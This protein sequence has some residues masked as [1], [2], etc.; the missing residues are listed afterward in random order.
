MGGDMN[1]SRLNKV[2]ALVLVMIALFV[3]S[4][5][6]AQEITDELLA[7]FEQDFQTQMQTYNI[8]GS[9]VAIVQNGK[10]V[11]AKGFGVR[12]L[13]TGEP[14]T[15]STVFRVGSTTKAMTSMMIATLVDEGVLS[16]DTPA[17]EI[18]PDFKLPTDELTQNVTLR[19]LM[20]MGTGLGTNMSA[21]HWDEYSA[22]D[23]LAALATLPILGEKG[24]TYF[25]N[26]QVYSSAAYIAAFATQPGDQDLYE[27]YKALMQERVFDP[28][29]MDTA[30]LSDD[31]ASVSDDYAASY[32]FSLAKGPEAN[33]L[34]PYA[35]IN[36]V[37]P[38]G[39][40]ITNVL[41]M[42]RFVITQ[43]NEGVNPDGE[44]V[45]S[46]E[47]LKETWRGQTK[48]GET[49]PGMSEEMVYAMGWVNE[50]Y[51]DVDIVWHNG[52]WD[53]FTSEMA[54][55]PD[56]KAGIVILS[57][58]SLGQGFN[59]IMRYK[60]IELLYGK[61]P[62]L[63]EQ[64]PVF[65]QG[66]MDELRKNAAMFSTSTIKADEVQA[67]L[68]NY[69]HGW[70]LEHRDDGTLWLLRPGW[71]LQLLPTPDGFVISSGVALGGQ[72]SF[73][74]G[75]K[76]SLVFNLQGETQELARQ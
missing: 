67:Y 8:P 71:E 60:F 69:E 36:T 26:N 31:P 68:G 20:G 51:D 46:A 54:L 41:D 38:A 42:A 52:G 14:V 50:R 11:Y 28:T 57:N 59:L 22:S 40:V 63:S 62:K 16:W 73:G 66:Q 55:L 18:Y 76:P 2:V 65:L 24:E 47:N 56:A 49:L 70:R 61:E 29:G 9:A 43:L 53:G 37:G 23:L 39:S 6:W 72:I 5:V 64:L 35:A 13:E 75:D 33:E 74:E 3:T 21:P 34:V 32:T 30:V 12:R 7:E 17:V 27:A 10:V 48:T 25:Y 1:T 19:E 44:R 58:S 45:V 4:N 15:T